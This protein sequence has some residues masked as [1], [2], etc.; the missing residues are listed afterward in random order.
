[1]HFNHYVLLLTI[2][3][4]RKDLSIR[5]LSSKNT[6]CV[7]QKV[8]PTS[9]LL[10]KK[11]RRERDYPREDTNWSPIK[12]LDIQLNTQL[13]RTI[14]EYNKKKQWL[15]R[16]HLNLPFKKKVDSLHEYMSRVCFFFPM[17]LQA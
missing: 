14:P 10:K 17:S 5:T 8:C 3:Y 16:V 13:I 4:K 12:Y 11:K 1:M 9:R 15:I 6:R 2:S 7:G